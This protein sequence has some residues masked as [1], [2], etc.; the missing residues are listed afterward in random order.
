MK[1]KIKR[2]K[3]GGED[4]S[5][6][7]DSSLDLVTQNIGRSNAVTGGDAAMQ[8]V[9]GVLSGAAS[10]A[11]LGTAIMPGIG[12][13][14]GAVGG[15]VIGSIGK[16]GSVEQGGFYEDPTLNLGTGLV[17]AFSNKGL[18]EEY[19]ELQDTARSHRAA[20][21]NTVSAQQKWN[22]KYDPYVYT[23]A[24]G[25]QI[26]SSLAYVDDGETINTPN[27]NIVE[28]PEKHQ[29]VDSNLVNLPEGSRI[30]SNTLKV[31]GTKK[32]YAKAYKEMSS[33]KISKGKDI[34]AE[35]SRK[36]NQMN[37][38]M[39]HD[40][41]FNLQELQKQG[42]KEYKNGL[43][44]F[45]DGGYVNWEKGK[46][47]KPGTVVKLNNRF[48][49]INQ[50]G[51][52]SLNPKTDYKVR[53]DQFNNESVPYQ[54]GTNYTA[55]TIV[56]INGRNYISNGDGTFKAYSNEQSYYGGNPFEI[57]VTPKG[58]GAWIRNTS[59]VESTTPEQNTTQSYSDLQKLYDNIAYGDLLNDRM[60]VDIPDYKVSV[61]NQSLQS[62]SW[63]KATDNTSIRVNNSTGVVGKRQKNTFT[64]SELDNMN[65]GDNA[66]KPISKSKVR[67]TQ[68]PDM[69]SVIGTE[70]IGDDTIMPTAAPLALNATSN[71]KMP[72][73]LPGDTTYNISDADRKR[74][75]REIRMDKLKSTIGDIAT[76]IGDTLGK[77]SPVI[78][79]LMAK[80]ERFDTVYNPY[81][82]QIADVMGK[83]RYDINPALEQIRQNQAITNYNMD[84]L[85]P[86]TGAGMAYRLQNAV[87]T[88]RAISDL[89][90]QKNNIDNQYIGD[91][92]NT[93]NNLGQQYVQAKNLSTDLN[94]RSRAAARNINR[95]GYS[96]FSNYLQNEELMRNLYNRDMA[97]LSLYDPFLESVF[98]T[99]DY[100][101]FKKYIK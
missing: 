17:G 51:T 84:Q 29:P 87:N 46:K 78:S 70:L 49:T 12:T 101:N 63:G 67:K 58:V 22:E 25:G 43:Q 14:I 24:Y 99:S 100:N 92:A 13:A 77:L 19:R 73:T 55:G 38:Q 48:Y 83:R 39:L 2:Y 94:A 45:Q 96:Q 20:L 1:K 35:N 42:Q 6:I 75:R 32:T 36:L 26:P 91:Y 60:T 95:A 34:F 89:Y 69:S 44:E 41:L 47:Y 50:D 23:A 28:V 76:S 54:K 11:S 61:P 80:P 27:G 21:A 82:M 71:F 88:N 90:S 5:T 57:T 3:L 15:A 56:N 93:L 74:L 81:A 8:S 62:N 10:G 98:K 52:M 59:N 33:K 18:R 9:Q 68:T 86:T 65:F 40:H 72:N 31:P 66:T 4:I 53:G 37:D 7:I 64:K 30:L 85:S 79:N 97:T 16:K